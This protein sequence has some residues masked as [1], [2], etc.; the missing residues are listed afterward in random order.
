MSKTT[1]TTPEIWTLIQDPRVQIGAYD[2]VAESRLLE[3]VDWRIALRHEYPT[4]STF[5]RYAPPHSVGEI[6]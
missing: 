6:I 3:V 5:D 1:I 4:E 2:P